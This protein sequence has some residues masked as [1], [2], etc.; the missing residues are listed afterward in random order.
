MSMNIYAAKKGVM[1]VF[2]HPKAGYPLHQK[3]AAAHLIV[4]QVYVV[5]RVEVGSWHTD[6]WL[7]EVPD[8]RFNSV[9]FDDV[10]LPPGGI[11]A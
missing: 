4:G 3:T 9:L 1:V 11:T 10:I 6:V 5:E 8:V 2:N 7:K